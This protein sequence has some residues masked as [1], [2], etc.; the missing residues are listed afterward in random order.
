MSVSI[1]AT[2]WALQFPK[3]GQYCLDCAWVT[4]VAQGCRVMLAGKVL[5]RTNCFCLHC[6][7]VLW[8]AFVRL[9]LLS[10][11]RLRVRPGVP[12]STRRHC[13]FSRAPRTRLRHLR[14]CTRDSVMH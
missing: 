14:R 6:Q 9:S 13:S 8:A 3:S 5:T 12:R 4:V 7:P 11:G 2:L 1:Y 10:R